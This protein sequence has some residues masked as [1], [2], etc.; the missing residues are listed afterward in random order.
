MFFLAFSKRCIAQYPLR[1]SVAAA[2]TLALAANHVY[3]DKG[4]VTS[5]N[6]WT[7]SPFSRIDK[8]EEVETSKRV[9]REGAKSRLLVWPSHEKA[10][11]VL[12]MKREPKFLSF[13]LDNKLGATLDFMD[14]G[15]FQHAIK[16]ISGMTIARRKEAT[17]VYSPTQPVEIINNVAD[18]CVGY[19]P[20]GEEANMADFVEQALTTRG[21]FQGTIIACVE[22]AIVPGEHMVSM[23]EITPFVSES[24]IKNWIYGRDGWVKVRFFGAILVETKK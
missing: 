7:V 1:L 10:M 16:G 11:T 8:I 4:E 23:L 12:D 9:Y 24:P 15:L 14:I 17:I 21:R 20:A 19:V 18:M 13:L 5:K 22:P 2:S 3:A 6:L